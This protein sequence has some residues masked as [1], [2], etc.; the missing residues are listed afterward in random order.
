MVDCPSLN[1]N[2]TLFEV[3]LY[4]TQRILE[5][6]EV[7]RKKYSTTLSYLR[8]VGYPS[9][10]WVYSEQKRRAAFCCPDKAR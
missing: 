8:R 10:K 7:L 6:G 5:A 3:V 4:V 9:K 2:L 1:S